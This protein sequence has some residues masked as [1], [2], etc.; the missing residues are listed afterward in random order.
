MKKHLFCAI[1]LQLCQLDL[2]G[3]KSL[4]CRK[5]QVPTP[6]KQQCMNDIKR[7]GK[8]VPGFSY[9]Y[10]WLIT[11]LTSDIPVIKWADS[12]VG[13]S[14]AISQSYS[15]S[16]KI[17]GLSLYKSWTRPDRCSTAKRRKEPTCLG[18]SPII[19]AVR[20]WPKCHSILVGSYGFQ[21]IITQI[22]PNNHI[23]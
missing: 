15:Q 8:Y 13:Y 2:G 12:L 16:P 4:T 5:L 1:F 7:C 18:K 19:W 6:A 9:I 23:G 21:R 22:I 10:R 14:A 11:P 3:C 20:S 17:P